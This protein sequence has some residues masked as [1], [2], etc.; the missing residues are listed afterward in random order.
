MLCPDKRLEGLG[1][2]VIAQILILKKDGVLVI[3]NLLGLAS[4]VLKCLFMSICS[5]FC[6][7][8]SAIEVH[9]LLATATQDH[10]KKIYFY[11]TAVFISHPHLSKISLGILSISSLFNWPIFSSM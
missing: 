7:E 4:I 11:A 10:D 6:C 3:N 2:Y 9:V 8:W 1:H 5:H